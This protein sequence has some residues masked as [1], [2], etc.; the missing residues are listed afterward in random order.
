M[1]RA[2]VIHFATHALEDVLNPRKSRLLLAVNEHGL[3]DSLDVAEVA[4]MQFRRAPTV[5]LAGCRTAATGRAHGF[6]QTLA[7]AFLAAGARD[8]VGS[9]WDIE[10]TAGR[11]FSLALHGALRAGLEP[12]RALREAQL[13]LLRSPN[14]QFRSMSAWAAM[15]LQS[16]N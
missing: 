3:Q 2:D 8:V 16:V 4:E 9:L 6:T 14:V 1:E 11:E 7:A 5:I 15:R 13:H 12:D 10:D